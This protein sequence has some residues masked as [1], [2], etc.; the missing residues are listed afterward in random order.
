[1]D[2]V[3]TFYIIMIIY[4][5]FNVK[6]GKFE[7]PTDLEHPFHPFFLYRNSSKFMFNLQ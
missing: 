1:M 2:I 4:Q 3:L 7:Q 6:V 5:N